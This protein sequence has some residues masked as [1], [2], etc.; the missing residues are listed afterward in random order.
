MTFAEHL[1]RLRGD[2]TQT[3]F[4]RGLG[5]PLTTYQRYEKGERVPDIELL[6]QIVRCVGLSADTLLGLERV[7][8]ADETSENKGHPSGNLPRN[9]KDAIIA[10]QAETIKTLTQAIKAL[11]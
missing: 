3:A 7:S 5:I 9:K 1:R 2:L 10:H 6:A 8:G 11:S 4:C